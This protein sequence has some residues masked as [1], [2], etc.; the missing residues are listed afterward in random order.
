MMYD[1]LKSGLKE[2]QKIE[3]LILIIMNV[4]YKGNVVV[5]YWTKVY[6]LLPQNSG[7]GGGGKHVH[8]RHL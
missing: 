5:V 6:K 2:R 4:K 3:D 8:H 1:I 7:G